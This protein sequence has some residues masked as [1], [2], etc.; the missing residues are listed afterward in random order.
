MRFSKQLGNIV[1]SVKSAKRRHGRN[2]MEIKNQLQDKDFRFVLLKPNDKIPYEPQWQKVRNYPF[3][4]K[5]V[6]THKGNLGIVAGYG[7]LIILDIDDK[8]LIEE[9]D[10]KMCTFSVKTGSGGRHYYLFCGEPFAKSYYVLGNKQGELRCS[11]SQV[12]VPNSI[13]P[14]GNKYEVFNE[15]PIRTVTK[16]IIKNI[17]GELLDKTKT[18]D[19]SRSGEE[20]GEVCSMVEA[21]YNFDDCDREMRL[22]DYSKWIETGIGYRIGTYCEA[23][24]KVKGG[25]YN[26]R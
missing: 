21:G 15:F 6:E 16:G 11:N 22:H 24:K 18:V 9:F 3:D 2:D 23:L 20:W 19:T 7:N 4:H 10:K 17:L 8:S 12:V 14:N 25:M 1:Q 26:G 13:H 5:K